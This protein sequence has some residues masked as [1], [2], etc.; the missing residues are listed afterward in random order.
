MREHG[1]N[2]VLVRIELLAQAPDPHP[3]RLRKFKKL[4][5]L[6]NVGAGNVKETWHHDLRMY[7][8]IKIAQEGGPHRAVAGLRADF[9]GKDQR[10]SA[11]V[12]NSRQPRTSFRI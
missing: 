10:I 2:G 6:L 12:S 7:A 3:T 9:F 8:A 11:Q 1:L 4:A 5:R